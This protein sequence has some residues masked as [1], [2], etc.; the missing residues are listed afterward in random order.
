MGVLKVL[1][2]VGFLQGIG[3]QGIIGI[4]KILIIYHTSKTNFFG[5][6]S[7]R[8]TRMWNPFKIQITEDKN[9]DK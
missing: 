6:Y 5:I 9:Y 8:D 2:Q 7:T 3:G 1:L 4:W